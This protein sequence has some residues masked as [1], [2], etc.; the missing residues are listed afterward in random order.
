MSQINIQL[1]LVCEPVISC[2]H[3]LTLSKRLAVLMSTLHSSTIIHHYIQAIASGLNGQL[4]HTS[5]GKAVFDLLQV[6]AGCRR[7]VT[8]SRP[9]LHATPARLTRRHNGAGLSSQMCDGAE[10]HRERWKGFDRS[11]QNSISRVQSGSE[12]LDLNLSK[13]YIK[14]W[15]LWKYD[16]LPKDLRHCLQIISGDRRPILSYIIKVLPNSDWYL[17]PFLGDN[18]Y[19]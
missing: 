15:R 8:V 2:G 18:F 16:T 19:N 11:W 1:W 13:D 17:F 7:H 9:P 5:L 12:K 4:S 3:I 6:P 10:K 14:I